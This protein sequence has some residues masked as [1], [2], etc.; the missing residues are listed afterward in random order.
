MSLLED[1]GSN[2]QLTD[3][4][5][6]QIIK[7]LTDNPSP[8]S[9]RKGWELLSILLFFFVPAS[10][11]IH[12]DVLRFVEPSSDPLLDCPEISTSRYAKH[13]LKR[14]QLPINC[15]KPSLPAVQE[16]RYQI[17]YPSMF[18]TS[19]E[20]LLEFQADKFPALKIPW[21]EHTLISI[22]LESGGEK[23]EGLFRLAA[24]PDQLH[25]GKVYCKFNITNKMSDYLDCKPSRF[26]KKAISSLKKQKLLFL[27][28]KLTQKSHK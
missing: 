25:R 3:E 22:I 18:G 12:S 11:E 15:F 20:E 21:V 6:I 14:L 10:P 28:K 4:I 23:A 19:L 24:D 8:A 13:C 2:N 5:F 27:S 1:G 26:L 7:Q 9:L 16:A 17:F